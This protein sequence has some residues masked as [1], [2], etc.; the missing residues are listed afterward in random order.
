[1]GTFGRLWVRNGKVY[2]YY[3]PKG[4]KATKKLVRLY[5]LTPADLKRGVRRYY[6]V[7]QAIDLFN[8]F[9]GK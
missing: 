4:K 2:R 8:A 5:D 6:R 1:M 3:Y 9:D 7:R